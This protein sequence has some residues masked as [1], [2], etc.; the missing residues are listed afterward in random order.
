MSD[1]HPELT[2]GDLAALIDRY[3]GDFAPRVVHAMLALALPVFVVFGMTAP[4]GSRHSPYPEA[5]R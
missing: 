1:R 2:V 3:R 5:R 4:L